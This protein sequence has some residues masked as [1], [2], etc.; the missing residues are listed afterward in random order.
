MTRTAIAPRA[1]ADIL[2]GM[3]NAACAEHL[4]AADAYR[5]HDMDA[6]ADLYEAAAG[7]CSGYM[8]ALLDLEPETVPLASTVQIGGGRDRTFR[9]GGGV[10]LREF[11]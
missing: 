7:A 6:T 10:P 3:L 8:N 11:E 9:V 1:T 5:A 4:A 2:F